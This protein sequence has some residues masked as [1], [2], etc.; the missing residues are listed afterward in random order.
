MLC[1]FLVVAYPYDRLLEP[2]RASKKLQSFPVTD[3][4][5]T[6]KQKGDFERTCLFGFFPVKRTFKFIRLVHTHTQTITLL[7]LIPKFSCHLSLWHKSESKDLYNGWHRRC[8]L[9]SPCFLSSHWAYKHPLP[10][11]TRTERR[12]SSQT[13]PHAGHNTTADNTVGHGHFSATRLFA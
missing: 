3:S 5:S 13:F 7:Q 11:E 9:V 4:K 6:S 12:Q 2:L 8:K 1:I 10:T